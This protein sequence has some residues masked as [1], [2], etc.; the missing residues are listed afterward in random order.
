MVRSFDEVLQVAES[1]RVSMRL[2]AYILAIDKVA[3]ALAVRGIY[4]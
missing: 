4:P 3:Q 2:A 1:H